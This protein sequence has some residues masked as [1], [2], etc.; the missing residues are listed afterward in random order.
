[1]KDDVLT[2]WERRAAEWDALPADEKQRRNEQAEREEE[3]CRWQARAAHVASCL[4]SVPRRYRAATV[5]H[6]KAKKWLADYLDGRTTRG[7][8]VVGPNGTGKTWIVLGLYRALAEAG[9]L[10]GRYVSMPTML[11][12]LRPRDTANTWATLNRYFYA[13]VLLVDDLGAHKPTEWAEEKFYEIIDHRW[14]WE[15]PTTAA[16]NIPKNIGDVIGERVASRLV[17]SCDVIRLTGS[18]RRRVP[19]PKESA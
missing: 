3:A 8:Y 10:G 17:G 4:A 5:E 19:W 7:L 9:K 2:T 15:L 6:P 13:S 1:M 12:E 16:T 14:Q 18:D 11:D